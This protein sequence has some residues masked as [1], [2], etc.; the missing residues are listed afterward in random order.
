[1]DAADDVGDDRLR[2]IEN[3]ALNFQLFVVGG[4]EVFVEMDDG[5]FAARLVAKV[6][7]DGGRSVSSPRRS[8]TTS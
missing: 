8:S 3:A 1:M 7:Q 4:K 6:A 2:G 5:V